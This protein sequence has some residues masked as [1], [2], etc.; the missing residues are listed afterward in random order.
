M[1]D[2]IDVIVADPIESGTQYHSQVLFHDHIIRDT[3]EFVDT[4][5]LVE[6]IDLGRTILCKASLYHLHLTITGKDNSFILE[7][8]NLGMV[9]MGQWIFAR[10][11]HTKTM[12]TERVMVIM[13]I[14]ELV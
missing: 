6:V 12:C 2:L 10:Y 5:D 1:D 13:I 8:R 3:E 4:K 9:I 11:Q 7:H 14:E